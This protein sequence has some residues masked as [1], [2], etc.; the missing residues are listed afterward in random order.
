M[1][2]PPPRSRVELQEGLIKVLVDLHYRPLVPAPITVIGSR[3]NSND[4]LLVAPVVTLHDELVSSCDEREP[5]H[6]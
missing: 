2:L 5:I 1:R 6:L 4:L 3:K